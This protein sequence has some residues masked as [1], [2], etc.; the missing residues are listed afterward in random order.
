MT[1]IALGNSD[2]K[3]SRVGLG[4]N[5]FGGRLDLEGSRKVIDAAIEH[6]ITFFDTADVYGN[7]GGSESILGEVLGERRKRIVLATKFGL[8]V[9]DS[10]QSQGASAGYIVR[11]VEASLKRLRTDWIDL[12]QLHR[13]DPATPLEE[14]LKALDALVSSGKVRYIGA[15]NLPA[16]QVAQAQHLARELGTA[17]FISSQD[18][19]SLLRR[20]IEQELVPALGHYGVGLIPYSPLASGLLTG[21]YRTG[22]PAP[23][24]SRLAGSPSRLTERLLTERNLRVA[25]ELADFA[26][27]RGHEPVELAFSWLAA[28]PAVSSII[29][30]ATTPEQVYQNV[31]AAHWTLSAED[32]ANID[33]ITAA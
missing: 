7:R 24:G 16:W 13:P 2:L 4:T 21:K 22:H 15:S 1:H 29:A 25:A 8:P 10:G 17:R 14:T 9:D 30:G 6:G 12:Y 27:S 23:A 5:N 33:R 20:D 19:Y 28:Q 31:T 18:G 3:V 11:A 32:L 26:K